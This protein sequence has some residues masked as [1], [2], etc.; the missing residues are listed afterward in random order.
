MRAVMAVLQNEET[1]RSDVIDHLREMAARGVELPE[2]VRNVQRELGF[3]E[4][5]IVPVM[6]S[7][8]RAFELPLGTVL[9]LREWP[10]NRDDPEMAP[11]LEHLRSLR[12][13]L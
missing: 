5:M 1:T 11:L 4:G 7:F 3:P 12:T 6:A 2:M 9:P 10:K 13:E 8:C